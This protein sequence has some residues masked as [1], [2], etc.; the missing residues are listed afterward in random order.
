[1][2]RKGGPEMRVLIVEDDLVAQKLMVN[3]L[4]PHGDCDIA[5]DGEEAI[6][7]FRLAQKDNRPY[8]LILMDIMMPNVSGLDALL[9]IR[10]ME[11]NVGIIGSSEVKVIMTTALGDPK[12]VINSYYKSGATSYLV[13]PIGREKLLAEVRNLGLI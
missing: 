5:V 1:M 10:E 4:S 9:K 8:D 3:Y 13:K 12:T 11:T 6:R 2:K 7:A